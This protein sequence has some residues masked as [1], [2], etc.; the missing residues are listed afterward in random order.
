[1]LLIGHRHW[2]KCQLLAPIFGNRIFQVDIL[3]T[4][5]LKKQRHWFNSALLASTNRLAWKYKFASSHGQMFFHG[6]FNL[7]PFKFNIDTMIPKTL[8]F[9]RSYIFQ[10]IL[11]GIHVEFGGC[12]QIPFKSDPFFIKPLPIW[13]RQNC[14]A[15][16]TNKKNETHDVFWDFLKSLYI[17]AWI[18]ES[19]IYPKLF[20]VFE[21][22]WGCC[23]RL[24]VPRFVRRL[25]Q[26][27]K[28]WKVTLFASRKRFHQHSSVP[29][30]R[31]CDSR[32]WYHHFSCHAAPAFRGKGHGM[33]P[34]CVFNI[35]DWPKK[36]NLKLNGVGGGWIQDEMKL[37]FVPYEIISGSTWL[38]CVFCCMCI[39]IIRKTL[40]VRGSR[41]Y[42][43]K[44]YQW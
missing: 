35:T 28:P 5:P 32:K 26:G 12:T 27:L 8:M 3:S 10:S 19:P 17:T 20:S 9:E 33:G 23:Q 11:F 7:P 43:A 41:V 16:S 30:L 21:C 25:L 40:V 42:L 1:M 6:I 4:A 44:P 37:T 18:V 2:W 36:L 13:M 29:T 24:G 15:S 14:H 22:F 38:K 34:L 39:Y 31:F